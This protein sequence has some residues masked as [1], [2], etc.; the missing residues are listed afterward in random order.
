VTVQQLTFLKKYSST[1]S[2]ILSFY[3]V[4]AL[5]LNLAVKSSFFSFKAHNLEQLL[6]F[7]FSFI[8]IQKV[9]EFVNK[10]SFITLKDWLCYTI[11]AG[12]FSVFMVVGFS[13]KATG[14]ADCVIFSKYQFLKAVFVCGGYFV[15]FLCLIILLYDKIDKLSLFSDEPVTAGY[16]GYFLFKHPFTISFL[17]LFICSIPYIVLSYPAIF[18]PWDTPDQI[19]WGYNLQAYSAYLHMPLLSD[20]VQII[21]HH[22]VVE[23]LLLHYFI[24]LGNLLCNYN[25]GVFLYVFFQLICFISAVSFLFKEVL[26]YFHLKIQ[27]SM[28]VLVYY[29]CH[30]FIQ[31]YMMLLAKDVI[32]ACFL[33]VFLLLTCV[34]L[35][36]KTLSLKYAVFW[37]LTMLGM[38]LF[39]HEGIYLIVP[40]L[41]LSL[42]FNVSKK[43]IT[44]TLMI[45]VCFFLAWNHVILPFYKVTP[46]SVREMLSLPFQQTARYVKYF[47]QKVT[48]DEKMAINAVL[49]YELLGKRYNPNLSDPV[50]NTFK[51]S[52]T[53]DQRIAYLKTWARMFWKEPRIY[54]EATIANKYELFYPEGRFGGFYL[55]GSFSERAM[56]Q[57]NDDAVSK[58]GI[59][60]NFHHPKGLK[61][62]REKYEQLREKIS[63]LPVFNFLRLASTYI[64]VLILMFFYTL[65]QKNIKAII[66]LAPCIMLLLIVI[67]GPCSG[68]YVRYIYPYIVTFP[69]LFVFLMHMRDKH[70]KDVE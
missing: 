41:F 55:Y 32:Y 60:F 37:I 51:H 69:F 68:S 9:T 65:R 12:L 13:F 19:L 59:A 42:F 10:K 4:F 30:P 14:T 21:N 57:I 29:L 26:T 6:V 36:N 66:L 28:I 22:P 25:F 18:R 33:A 5:N 2:I 24:V 7:L 67:A 45:I 20:N 34:F 46:G 1:V 61:N 53:K 40:T 31:N 15:L 56:K 50:K 54:F 16:L 8:L 3:I 35:E 43:Q 48:Q 27:Y 64:W 23:T 58:G 47:P 63:R 52:S 11:P 44:S 62:Y 38:V 49:A 17:I 39:R 70:P